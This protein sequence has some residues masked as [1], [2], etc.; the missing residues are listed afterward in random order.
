MPPKAK[1]LEMENNPDLEFDHF[2]AERLRRTVAEVREMDNDEYLS[3][4]VYYGR[5]AQREQ[6]AMAKR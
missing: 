1:Y 3:W 4:C 5:K 2:L 6:I